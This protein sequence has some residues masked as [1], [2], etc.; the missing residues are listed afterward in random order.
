MDHPHDSDLIYD[1]KESDTEESSP[2]LEIMEEEGTPLGEED[3]DS[4][5][6]GG[7]SL[8]SIEEGDFEVLA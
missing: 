5:D 4:L 8:C 1:P 2:D 3:V 7:G 6:T